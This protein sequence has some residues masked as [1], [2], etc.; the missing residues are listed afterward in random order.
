MYKTF[1]DIKKDCLVCEKC[2]LCKTRTNVVFGAGQENAKILIIGEAPG[3]NEDLQGVPFVGRGGQLLDKL[4]SQ[5]GLSR[6]KNVYIANTVKC[7]PPKNRDPLPREQEACADWLRYQVA[8]M[9]PKIIVCLGRVSAQRFISRD[10]KVTNQHGEFFER[11]GVLMMGTYHPAAL[12]RN[13][14]N[15]PFAVED[16]IKLKEKLNELS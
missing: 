2:E 4:L 15:K 16:L 14:H 9:Q 8:V 13:P 12:L 7:R 10:F 3:E 11:D 5:V 1:D 6:D